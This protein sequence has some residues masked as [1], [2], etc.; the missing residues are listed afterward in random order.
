[1]GDYVYLIC[2]RYDINFDIC[3]TVKESSHKN[4]SLS[5][6]LKVVNFDKNNLINNGTAHV[7]QARF[8]YPYLHKN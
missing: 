8:M 3:V 2:H 7:N 1:M 4:G 5:A 6:K